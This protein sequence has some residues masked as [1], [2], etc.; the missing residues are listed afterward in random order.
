[1]AV[2]GWSG[3]WLFGLVV[4]YLL[5][6]CLVVVGIVL[7]VIVSGSFG[8]MMVSCGYEVNSVDDFNSFVF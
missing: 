7:R 5:W 2:S 3:L 1:M 8:W 6:L 4:C